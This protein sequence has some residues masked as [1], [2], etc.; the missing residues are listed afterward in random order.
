MAGTQVG[1]GILTLE[2][3]EG[4]WGWLATL[5]HLTPCQT[6]RKNGIPKQVSLQF[7][8]APRQ[9]LGGLDLTGLGCE[10][11]LTS[12]VYRYWGCEGVEDKSLLQVPKLYPRPKLKASCASDWRPVAALY[13]AC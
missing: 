12:E 13:A 4:L 7:C 2:S 11:G 3:E 8:T 9:V 6:F 1:W 10:A 5:T